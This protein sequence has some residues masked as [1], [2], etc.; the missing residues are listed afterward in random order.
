MHGVL[1]RAAA[2]VGRTVSYR[3][4]VSSFD[5]ALRV[6]GANLAISIIPAQVPG[7]HPRRDIAVIPLADAW[8]ARRFAICFRDREALQPASARLLAFLIERA[9]SA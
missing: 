2:R 9:A 4:I 8:A 3:V 7:A 1:H 5:A 6:V